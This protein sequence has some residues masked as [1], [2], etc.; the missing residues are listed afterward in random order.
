MRRIVFRNVARPLLARVHTRLEV[1]ITGGSRMSVDPGDLIGRELAIS[2]IWEPEVTAVFRSMLEQGD[3]C[4]DVGANIGYFTLLAAGLV[5][6][7]GHVY[8][9]EPSAEL[10][11][12]LEA[13]LER[14][15]VVNVSAL[16]LAAGEV[17]GEAVLYEGPAKNRGEGS[18]VPATPAG[19]PLPVPLRRLDSVVPVEAWPRVRLIKVDVE[20][21]EAAV[22]RGLGA[23]LD[24]GIRPAIIVEVTERTRSAVRAFAGAYGLETRSLPRPHLLSGAVK[25]SRRPASPEPGDTEDLLLL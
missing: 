15:G 23:L 22:L 3:V 12:E 25:A 18:L 10:F 11:A 14:N 5:G 24:A 2:G 9:F 16:R 6:P 13:N 8:A 17:D 4:L 1:R 7:V 19:A 21:S 20:G